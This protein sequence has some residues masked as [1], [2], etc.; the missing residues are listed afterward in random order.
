MPLLGQNNGMS[1]C[2]TAITTYRLEHWLRA[3]HGE[4]WWLGYEVG[5]VAELGKQQER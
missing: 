5:W 3:K 4:D 2:G 1:F